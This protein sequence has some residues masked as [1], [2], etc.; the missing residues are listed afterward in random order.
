MAR[1][2]KWLATLAAAGLIS[3]GTAAQQSQ[4]NDPRPVLRV[5][6]QQVTNTGTLS[7]LRE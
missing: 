6:V 3:G 4:A 1:R 7:P 2:F 5:A